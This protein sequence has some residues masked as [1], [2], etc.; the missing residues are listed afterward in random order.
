MGVRHLRGD[1]ALLRAAIS[2]VREFGFQS[3]ERLG[4]VAEFLERSVYA[5]GSLRSEHGGVGFALLNPP[6]RVGAFSAVRVL[7]DGRP[8]S[9]ENAFVRLEGHAVERPLSDIVAAR[10]VELRPGQ[11][12][13]FRLVGVPSGPGH[14]RVR[15]ELQSIAVPPLVWFEFSDTIATPGAP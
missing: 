2:L 5:P 9:P 11:P 12:V 6:L 15:L 10:P 1:I 3:A 14:H 4:Q 13:R 7:W 8:V